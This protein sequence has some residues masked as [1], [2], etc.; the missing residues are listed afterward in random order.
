MRTEASY[1]FASNQND[2]NI[3]LFVSGEAEVG[4]TDKEGEDEAVLQRRTLQKSGRLKLLHLPKRGSHAGKI[5]V[6]QLK[7]IQFI[8]GDNMI[9][10]Q[11]RTASDQMDT[12][13][14]RTSL[15]KL[16]NAIADT[17]SPSSDSSDLSL[18]LRQKKLRDVRKCGKR[19]TRIG[20]APVYH[21]G[22]PTTIMTL[23]VSRLICELSSTPSFIVFCFCKNTD[24]FI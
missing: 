17:V 2:I 4:D 8:F 5:T 10:P 20:K 24:K 22:L 11:W 16:I 15:E 9:L 14:D 1:E 6:D 21:K 12:V 18:D 19:A 3:N 23:E 13:L 7:A